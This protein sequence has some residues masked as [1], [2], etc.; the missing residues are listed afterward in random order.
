MKKHLPNAVTCLNLLCGCLALTNIFAGR[1][2]VGAYFVAAAAA[3]TSQAPTSSRPAKMLVSAKQPN[4]RFRQVTALGRCFFKGD[5][6][7]G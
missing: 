1:L 3:A 4:S 2:D 6:V 7:M 5:G